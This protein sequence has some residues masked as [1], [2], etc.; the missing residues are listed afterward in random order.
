MKTCN[1]RTTLEL[2]VEKLLWGLNKFYTHK[3]LPL[4]LTLSILRPVD[5][6]KTV[7]WV[8]SSVDLYPMPRFAQAALPEYL[9]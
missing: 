3:T 7:R 4:I 6:S 1:R 9:G 2:S 5:V 8:A